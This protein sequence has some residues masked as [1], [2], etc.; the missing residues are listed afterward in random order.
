MGSLD[1]Q[2]YLIESKKAGIYQTD[3]FGMIT[4]VDERY[5]KISAIDRDKAIGKLWI[6]HIFLRDQEQVKRLW[7]KFDKVTESFSC[8]FR[9]LHRDG[10]IKSVFTIAHKI[11]DQSVVILE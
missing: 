8:E 9:F 2:K 5:S 10:S 4:F 1:F 3:E 7:L 6:D 11:V